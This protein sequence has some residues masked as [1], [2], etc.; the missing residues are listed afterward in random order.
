MIYKSLS[1][2]LVSL[3]ISHFSFVFTFSQSAYI[4]IRAISFI[5]QKAKWYG[6]DVFR[7]F[8]FSL[9]ICIDLLDLFLVTILMATVYMVHI[10]KSKRGL[11]PKDWSDNGRWC[12]GVVWFLA[13]TDGN[14]IFHRPHDKYFPCDQARKNERNNS[15]NMW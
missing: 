6:L 8:C 5:H 7:R 13:S 4:P 3:M 9:L 12:F 15:L 1:P 11:L 2:Y 14:S 10:N